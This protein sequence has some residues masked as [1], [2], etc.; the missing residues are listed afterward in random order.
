MDFISFRAGCLNPLPKIAEANRNRTCLSRRQFLPPMPTG[1]PAPADGGP[2]RTGPDRGAVRHATDQRPSA[3]ATRSRSRGASTAPSSSTRSGTSAPPWPDGRDHQRY[4]CIP[5]WFL[6]DCPH[7]GS[8]VE[9]SSRSHRSVRKQESPSPCGHRIP[10]TANPSGS[11]LFAIPNRQP[12]HSPIPMTRPT[13]TE[14][15]GVAS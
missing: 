8:D 11:A 7:I 9:P 5:S 4:P 3:T 15:P 10:R 2:P 12:S 6:T 13:T 14:C 1:P